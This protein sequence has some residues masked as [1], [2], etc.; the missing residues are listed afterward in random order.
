MP[1]LT[2]RAFAALA[3]AGLAGPAGWAPDA[4]AEAA[5]KPAIVAEGG[6]AEE[7]IADTRSALDLAISQG[8]D[9]IQV[10]L[11]PT[12]E[13]ALVARRGNELSASTDVAAHAEFADRKADKTIG[14]QSVSG[15]FAE[16]F[17]V[18]ELQTLT[19]REAQPELRPQLTRLN[20]K[21]P[22]LTLADVLQIA[23]DGCVKTART[24]GVCARLL[25]PAY[26][27]TVGLDVVGRF[28]S[29][30]GV[31][32]YVSPAA[33]IWVQASDPDALRAFA[34]LSRVRRM[35]VIEA[36][37]GSA[38]QMTTSAGLAGIHGYAEAIAAD[39]DLLID[40]NAAAFPAPTTLA[41]DAH[42]AGLKVFSRTARG[43]NAFLPPPLQQGDRRSRS[44]PAQ[45]GDVDKLLVALFADGLDGVATDLPAQADK[46]RAAVLDA[47][48]HAR[49]KRG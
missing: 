7:R 8:C 4:W 49:A 33:A 37:A 3:A 13:G 6:A 42:N 25:R 38:S 15:W 39:Q 12:K 18:A 41:L 36:G 45:R 22:I 9:F 23:R 44:F 20:G 29:E 28:A 17:T 26:F 1:T 32:G 40:P 19:C 43:Q 27:D 35:L 11:V 47:I 24:I 5:Q 46:A 21:E 30:L 48:R 16:D 31:E 14:G 2:R 10:D 34:R